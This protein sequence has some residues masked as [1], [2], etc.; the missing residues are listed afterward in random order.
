MSER[1]EEQT[2][3]S[4]V[5][6]LLPES[7]SAVEEPSPLESQLQPQAEGPVERTVSWLRLAYCI[8][9]LLAVL[10][11]FTVWRFHLRRRR[12]MLST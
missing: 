6:E 7:V 9:F 1:V 11:I 10:S 3:E 5:E 2:T 8:I 12:T 4:P